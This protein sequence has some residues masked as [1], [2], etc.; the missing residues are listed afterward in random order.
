MSLNG[1][2]S[3][4]QQQQQ[5]SNSSQSNDSSAEMELSQSARKCLILIEDADIVFDQMD[6]GFVDAI[7][8]LAASSKRPVIVVAT[9]PNCAYLQKLINQNCITFTAP[10]VLNISKFMTVLSLIENC[11]VLLDDLISLYLYNNKDL[12]KTILE[13]QFFIQSGGDRNRNEQKSTDNGQYFASPTKRRFSED[14][15]CGTDNKDDNLGKETNLQRSTNQ[16]LYTHKTLFE[17]YTVC[18]NLEQRIPYPVDFHLLRTNLKDIFKASPKLEHCVSEQQQKNESKRKSRSPKKTWLS[19]CTQSKQQQQNPLNDLC[20]FYE[21]L[22]IATL[23]G[24]ATEGNCFQNSTN[25]A[26]FVDRL[27]PHIEEEMAH[28]LIERSLKCNLETQT[29]PYNL[30]DAPKER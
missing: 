20:N 18:Q 12:R 13:L 6:A 7:Y 19:S 3:K 24:S 5:Q 9:N 23:L 27:V 29:C 17:F 30:F 1:L 16:K 28:D 14:P 2:K 25:S 10:N 21:N 22:S 8:T 15:A 26:S 11:P 4:K